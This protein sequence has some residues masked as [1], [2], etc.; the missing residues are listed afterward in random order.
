MTPEEKKHLDAY[1]AERLKHETAYLEENDAE[2]N[3]HGAYI[4]ISS[5]TYHSIRLD[6]MLRDYREYLIRKGV[7]K[8]P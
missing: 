2:K 8:Q 6:S 1:R 3:E 4:Y 7:V 5:N